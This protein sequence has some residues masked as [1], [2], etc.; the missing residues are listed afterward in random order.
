MEQLRQAGPLQMLNGASVA[1]LSCDGNWSC[2]LHFLHQGTGGCDYGPT[3]RLVKGDIALASEVKISKVVCR[4]NLDE[5]GV[6]RGDSCGSLALR[7]QQLHCPSELGR[8]DSGG[9]HDRR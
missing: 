5:I 6:F 3:V 7:K 1:Q 2:F 4:G 8:R 9:R